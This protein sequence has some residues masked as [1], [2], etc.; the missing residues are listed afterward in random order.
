[1]L[2]AQKI[3]KITLKLVRIK[4]GKKKILP[5]NADNFSEKKILKPQLLKNMHF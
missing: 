2:L 1:M 5:H 3:E 4:G